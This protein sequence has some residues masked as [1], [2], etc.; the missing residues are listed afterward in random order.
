[1]RPATSA[2]EA[3]RE[4]RLAGVDEVLQLVVARMPETDGKGH[5]YHR[6]FR[7]MLESHLLG[8]RLVADR[9]PQKCEKLYG[10]LYR[11]AVL[12][13]VSDAQLAPLADELRYFQRERRESRLKGL[14]SGG[15]V[16]LVIYALYRLANAFTR[17]YFVWSLRT[18]AAIA[19]T[20][21]VVV[22]TSLA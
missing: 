15:A 8:D 16:L 1:L 11:E 3:A 18:A 21:A 4:A 5:R 20:G 19:A 10:G 6:Q 14:A 2:S 13:D 22:L 7:T 9:F 17:G 12:L